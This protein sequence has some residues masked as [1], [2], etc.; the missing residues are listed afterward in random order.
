MNFKKI[1][2]P[3]SKFKSLD[4][5]GPD[6]LINL[7][8]LHQTQGFKTFDVLLNHLKTIK[9]LESPSTIDIVSKL[10]RKKFI[11]ESVKIS[12]KEI[13]QIKPLNIG[14]NQTLTDIAVQCKCLEILR[15]NI[16]KIDF[17]F[18]ILDLGAG[19]GY[20]SYALYFLSKKIQENNF[21]GLTGIDIYEDLIVHCNSLK[22]KFNETPDFF[23]LLNFQSIDINDFLSQKPKEFDIIHVGFAIERPL[24]EKIKESLLKSPNGVVLAPIKRENDSDQDLTIIKNDGETKIMNTFFSDM[25]EKDSKDSYKFFVDGTMEKDEKKEGNLG[26][27]EEFWGNEERKKEVER[28][29]EEAQIEFKSLVDDLKKNRKVGILKMKEMLEDGKIKAVLNKINEFKK[30]LKRL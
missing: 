22:T 1:L 8:M 21:V 7:S 26:G 23:K 10:Q 13:S 19:S 24:L 25:V 12:E 29:I 11:P 18:K 17:P 20:I 16:E 27:K 15:E 3:F 5:L 6:L 28:K 14:C 30:T 4:Q 2:F 9:I